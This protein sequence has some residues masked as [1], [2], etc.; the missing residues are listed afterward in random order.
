MNDAGQK[1]A[2]PPKTMA[3]EAADREVEMRRAKREAGAE[4]PQPD[5]PDSAVRSAPD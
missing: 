4:T 5:L 1:P 2:N 3:E